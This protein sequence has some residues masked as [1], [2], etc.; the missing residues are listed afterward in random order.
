MMEF[1]QRERWLL[2]GKLLKFG[3]Y[4]KLSK[5]GSGDSDVL[6]ELE[7]LDNIITILES[8]K[9]L[10]RAQSGFTVAS[11]NFLPS[12]TLQQGGKLSLA[13][14][15]IAK[16]FSLSD[17]QEEIQSIQ[18]TVASNDLPDSVKEKYKSRETL[19]EIFSISDEL[20]EDIFQT[21]NYLDDLFKISQEKL[22]QLNPIP[23]GTGFLVGGTH[24]LTN[25]H[26]IPNQEIARQSIAQFN[27]VKDSF[28]NTEVVVEYEFEPETLFVTNPN[29]DYTLV[30]LKSGFQKKPAGYQMGWIQLVEKEDTIAPGL[31]F[32]RDSNL[33]S[34][35]E[36][37][38]AKLSNQGQIRFER[39]GYNVF[40]VQSDNNTYYLI[41]E[42]QDSIEKRKNLAIQQ[43]WQEIERVFQKITNDI[44][45]ILQEIKKEALSNLSLQ[46]QAR[47]IKLIDDFIAPEGMGEPVFIIQHPQGRTQEVVLFENKVLNDGLFKNFLRYTTDADYGS[48]GS[49]VFNAQWELV[50]LHHAAIP[51]YDVKADASKQDYTED[52]IA[53]QG[54][55]I[56]RIIEDLKRKSTGNPKLQSFIEDFV[57]T[58]EQLQK[59]PLPS[60]L[61][62]NGISDYVAID[63]TIA[64]ASCAIDYNERIDRELIKAGFNTIKLWN[65]DGIELRSFVHADIRRIAFSRDEKTIVSVGGNNIK[66]WDIESG[67]LIKTLSVPSDWA[68]QEQQSS[69][70]IRLRL[71]PL[72]EGTSLD[73]HPQQIN[74]LAVASGNDIITLWNLQDSEL[75]NLGGKWSEQYPELEKLSGT[76]VKFSMDGKLLAS[77]N[78]YNDKVQVWN[79]EEWVLLDSYSVPAGCRDFCFNPPDFDPNNNLALNSRI[80]VIALE[81]GRVQI[82]YLDSELPPKLFKAHEKIPVKIAFE[83]EYPFFHTNQNQFISVGGD[84]DIKVWSKE[85]DLIRELVLQEFTNIFSSIDLNL[86]QRTLATLS[87]ANITIWSVDEGFKLN[88]VIHFKAS[89]FL[90]NI[91]SLEPIGADVKFN[92]NLKSIWKRNLFRKKLNITDYI[93]VEA[94]FS[95]DIDGG[96]TILTLTLG[97]NTQNEPI[98]F[99]LNVVP[100]DEND[101]Y[102]TTNLDSPQGGVQGGNLE[103]IAVG[104]FN[105]IAAV[106]SCTL[107]DE[108]VRVSCSVYINSI[109]TV[110]GVLGHLP[111][112]NFFPKLKLIGASLNR[113]NSVSQIS[114][115]FKGAISEVRLWNVARSEAEIKET[116]SQRLPLYYFDSNLIGYWRLEEGQDYKVYDLTGNNTLGLIYGAK[117]LKASQPPATP[118]EFSRQF[119]Q[120]QDVVEISNIELDIES[121]FTVEAWVQF[122]FGNCSIISQ[123]E[124][125]KAGYSI[126]CQ[127][128]KI[129]LELQDSL[130]SQKAF[131]E[132][133]ESPLLD[134]IWH[135]LAFVW[136][137]TS[138]EIKLYVDGK[139]QVCRL[140]AGKFQGNSSQAVYQ[141]INLSLKNLPSILKIGEMG[142]S[143]SERDS[144]K[145]SIAEV[146]IWKTAKTQTEI[147]SNQ[148]RRLTPRDGDWSE[149]VANRRLDSN[150]LPEPFIL[151]EPIAFP[152]DESI[153]II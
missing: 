125:G 43:K 20:S 94:W 67:T 7:D 106:V 120:P 11:G 92:P 62:F 72:D 14:C 30:Q 87:K 130:S 34:R 99:S 135:H 104:K 116:Q 13:V 26:I 85:G 95:P 121:G 35:F 49:P 140:I 90:T 28:E 143:T 148:F 12:S 22:T 78:P 8:R 44:Q 102:L 15:R 111:Y 141:T 153:P 79:T 96:G 17:F 50:A 114:D 137:E 59:P 73:F 54:V 16:I 19:K 57:I 80:L 124:S 123:I 45:V 147:I 61:K 51:N 131:L 32:T 149:L 117:W 136:E 142:S 77:G 58:S 93:T 75:L 42:S 5:G 128:G 41:R 36:Q 9:R 25:W 108:V 48:S 52:V 138:Q 89:N 112:F 81:D 55:R 126:N 65:R 69:D 115:F 3:K 82:C 29:L 113:S 127:E 76:L 47:V 110:D 132:T 83:S 56:C 10:Q 118:L 71:A 1:D 64:F 33:K 119:T 2:Q 53:Q 91:D 46:N 21:D 66:V 86:N 152:S 100:W 23:W 31:I 144:S 63:G 151:D 74:L 6:P 97:Q 145:I 24:L 146:R 88:S 40:E 4:I 107:S 101:W 38:F 109:I 105:H 122:E 129:R 84:G 39:Q 98:L 60:G 150:K 134:G 103:N 133:Q 139:K 70:A 18:Y 37:I 68:N 27:Y